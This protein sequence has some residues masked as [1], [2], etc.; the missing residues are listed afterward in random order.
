MDTCA[1]T[2]QCDGLGQR[3]KVRMAFTTQRGQ[4]IKSHRDSYGHEDGHSFIEFKAA[5]MPTLVRAF[6]D[7]HLLTIYYTKDNT[8]TDQHAQTHFALSQE[9]GVYSPY[10]FR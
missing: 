8:T 1:L 3:T 10:H 7:K 4:I 2:E 6:L 9:C 5:I